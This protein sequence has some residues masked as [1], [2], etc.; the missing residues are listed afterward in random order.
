MT[1]GFLRGFDIYDI[2]WGAIVASSRSTAAGMSDA[3]RSPDSAEILFARK[4]LPD[5][6]EAPCDRAYWVWHRGEPE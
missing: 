4:P 2:H 3:R 6:D 1:C 5:P